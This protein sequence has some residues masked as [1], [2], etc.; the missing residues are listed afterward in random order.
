MTIAVYQIINLRT[1][2]FYIGSAKSFETRYGREQNWTK[3]HNKDLKQDAIS[4]DKFLYD[5]IQE[6]S[7]P[8]EAL[9]MEQ[10]W[11]DFYVMNNLWDC[12]LQ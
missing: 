5:K 8:E 9:C 1:F 2:Q 11:L 6:C 7:S 4:G 3:H 12:L 10:L